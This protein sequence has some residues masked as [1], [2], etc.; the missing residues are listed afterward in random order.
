MGTF[1][2][3]AR[4]KFDIIIMIAFCFI[5]AL[6]GFTLAYVVRENA[7]R[8][9]EVA[10]VAETVLSAHCSQRA[11]AQSQVEQTSDLLAASTITVFWNGTTREQMAAQL[12]SQ[13]AFRDTFKGLDCRAYH[14]AGPN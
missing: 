9:E 7:H 1:L 13:R 3:I 5:V 2:G 6:N 10:A 11:Y 4:D 14:G 12:R 8:A